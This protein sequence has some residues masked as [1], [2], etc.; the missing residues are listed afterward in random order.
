MISSA[1]PIIIHD[2]PSTWSNLVQGTIGAIVGAVIGGAVAA[3]IAWK[4]ATYTINQETARRRDEIAAEQAARKA[5]RDTEIKRQSDLDARRLVREE[6]ALRESSARELDAAFVRSGPLFTNSW[7]SAEKGAFYLGIDIAMRVADSRHAS[8]W[9]RFISKLD[10][11]R[12]EIYLLAR[13]VNRPSDDVQND[14]SKA[15]TS[16]R[17][18]I[19]AWVR[20][21]EDVESRLTRNAR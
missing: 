9:P 18:V 16:A 10:G 4:V 14:A 13:D 5:E 12:S 21:P 3:V 1:P 6:R 20:D 8:D 17:E 2:A 19:W 11:Y 7:S 15:V